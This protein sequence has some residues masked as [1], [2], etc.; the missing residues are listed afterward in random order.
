MCNSNGGYYEFFYF[1]SE[2]L[3]F[4]EKLC[5]N[6]ILWNYRGYGKSTGSSS[7]ENA[8]SDGQEVIKYFKSTKDIRVLGLHGESIGGCIA[9][10]LAQNCGC[11]FLFADRAFASLSNLIYFRYGWLSYYLYKLSGLPD[12][13]PGL[14][15]MNLSCNKLIAADHLDTLV[16]DIASIK[17][18]VALNMVLQTH[19]NI[20]DYYYGKKWKKLEHIISQGEA[21]RLIKA[22]DSVMKSTVRDIVTEEKGGVVRTQPL[23]TDCQDDEENALRVT[24]RIIQAVSGVNAAGMPFNEVFTTKQV[25][26]YLQLWISALEVWGSYNIELTDEENEFMENDNIENAV[27]RIR[28]AITKLKSIETKEYFQEIEEITAVFIKLLEHLQDKVEKIVNSARSFQNINSIVAFRPGYFM[29]ISCGHGGHF[30]KQDYRTYFYHLS[31]A[32]FLPILH[33][34]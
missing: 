18:S 1:Q 32:S 9:I 10:E 29:P 25:Q 22:M 21:L 27:S 23:R 14:T 34:I 19:V 24:N 31:R 4:Y 33:N 7:M 12:F 16:L 20:K 6:V 28:R 30:N 26:F 2:W 8:I 15:Y 5:V 3:E 11:D 13:S 17:S